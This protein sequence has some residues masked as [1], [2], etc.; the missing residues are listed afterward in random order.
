VTTAAQV[1]SCICSRKSARA[2]R[3]PASTVAKLLLLL[4]LLLLGHQSGLPN[5]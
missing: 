2:D 5:D 4:L 1:A 3:M